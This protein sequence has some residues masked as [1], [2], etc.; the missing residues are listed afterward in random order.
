MSA[1]VIVRHWCLKLRAP[2]SAIWL[3]EFAGSAPRCAMVRLLIAISW[4]E[5]IGKFLEGEGISACPPGSRG[6]ASP[7]VRDKD[8]GQEERE[9]AKRT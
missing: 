1:A 2:Q 5:R 6:A 3:L 8:K 7:R 4:S 9:G